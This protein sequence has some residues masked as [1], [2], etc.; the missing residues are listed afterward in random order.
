MFCKVDEALQ[1][2]TKHHKTLQNITKYYKTLQNITKHY[3][4]RAGVESTVSESTVFGALGGSPSTG[5]PRHSGHQARRPDG[6]CLSTVEFQVAL[7]FVGLRPRAPTLSSRFGSDE[8]RKGKQKKEKT[9]G[10]IRRVLI[11]LSHFGLG[12][13]TAFRASLCSTFG[14]YVLNSSCGVRGVAHS[15]LQRCQGKIRRIRFWLL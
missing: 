1:I 11:F 6:I 8:E 4:R 10:R 9:G 13:G 14:N 5:F 2:I 3:K 7:K 12:E 15:L